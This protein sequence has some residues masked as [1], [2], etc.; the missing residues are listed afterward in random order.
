VNFVFE[1]GDDVAITAAARFGGAPT[2]VASGRAEVT[3]APEFPEVTLDLTPGS[4]AILPACDVALQPVLPDFFDLQETG[5]CKRDASPCP[6]EELS[7]SRSGEALRCVRAASRAMNAPGLVCADAGDVGPSVVWRAAPR[8]RTEACVFI[9][10][11]G[12]FVRC[13]SGSASDP[14][15]CE[16]TTAC[17]RPATAFAV[18][19]GASVLD[20]S[21]ADISCVPPFP[22]PLTFS[23]TLPLPVQGEAA[24]ALLQDPQGA[25]A[26]GA[27][28]FDI[29][30]VAEKDV[31]C[32][33]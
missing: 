1:D 30:S 14:S 7:E 18:L 21:V 29:Y 9:L 13:A 22:V 28:F 12:H 15:G 19:S 2:V 20:G 10:A 5:L 25:A 17:L 27:C 8:P 33:P 31:P 4:P 32:G 11:T 24:I 6:Q 3:A 26:E 23:V 16:L